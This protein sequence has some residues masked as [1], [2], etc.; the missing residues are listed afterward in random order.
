MPLTI[1]FSLSKLEI[2]TLILSDE[3]PSLQ[4]HSFLANSDLSCLFL[5]L[6][7]LTGSYPDKEWRKTKTWIVRLVASSCVF[8]GCQ[9]DGNRV[10]SLSVDTAHGDLILG[11]MANAF[12]YSFFLRI[13]L[14]FLF[15]LKDTPLTQA[16]KARAFEII[17][18]AQI[19]SSE[20]KA[21]SCCS[22]VNKENMLK[23][24]DSMQEME[25]DDDRSMLD[26]VSSSDSEITAGRDDKRIVVSCSLLF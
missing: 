10:F 26:M 23:C 13:V 11:D 15:E 24:Y 12:D 7:I 3:K 5:L 1:T 4:S 20:T 22:Y 19:N 14:H 18:K 17:L 6:I 8:P 16:L 9:D 25:E 2:F 21:I